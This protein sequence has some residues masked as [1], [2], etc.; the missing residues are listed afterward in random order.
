MRTLISRPFIRDY[1]AQLSRNAAGL[2][3]AGKAQ[4]ALRLEIQAEQARQACRHP[5]PYF[6]DDDRTE[7]QRLVDAGDVEG[8]NALL[9]AE[10]RELDRLDPE[11]VCPWREMG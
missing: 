10:S 3:M 5:L 9:E 11:D 2:L 4:T 6:L 1:A 8:V 7:F